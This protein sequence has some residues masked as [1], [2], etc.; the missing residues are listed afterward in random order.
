MPFAPNLPPSKSIANRLLVKRVVRGL[1]L[2]EISLDWAEDIHA[3]K[4]VLMSHGVRDAGEAGTAFRFGM[5]YAAALDGE[6]SLLTGSERLLQRPIEPLVTALESLGAQLHRVDEGWQIHG[7]Q[8]RGGRV[9]LDVSQ[10]SQFESALRL[11]EP[12]MSQ[13]LEVISKGDTVSRPYVEMTSKVNPESWPPPNDWSNAL[14]WAMAAVMTSHDMTLDL[15]SDHLQGDEAWSHWGD[16]LGFTWH[17]Q[18]SLLKVKRPEERWQIDLIDNPDLAQPIVAAAIGMRRRGKL[19]GL[20]TLSH[21][22]VDRLKA[23]CDM[24]DC[25]QV[26]YEVTHASLNFDARDAIFPEQ[27]A[28]DVSG[29][30]RM[31]MMWAL[32]GLKMKVELRGSNSV[33]KS[34]PKFWSEWQRWC[35]EHQLQMPILKAD[36]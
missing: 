31:A 15:L 12:M 32:L 35:T 24:L 7:A 5:A 22:E 11:V 28:I 6:I 36:S 1:P 34:D 3:M 20:S 29:D 21:K 14:F 4:R 9:E 30:H 16:V 8:L 2:P 10:S 13:P 26:T 23:I 17:E 33:A 19:T 18:S 25:C 27:V